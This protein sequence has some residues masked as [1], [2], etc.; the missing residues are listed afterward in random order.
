MDGHLDQIPTLDI[1][2]IKKYFVKVCARKESN[3]YSMFQGL[4]GHSFLVV[5]AYGI[6]V[7]HHQQAHIQEATELSKI[8]FAVHSKTHFL[9]VLL[10]S[11]A[12]WDVQT[13]RLCQIQLFVCLFVYLGQCCLP[14]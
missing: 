8:H 6:S 5:L 4:L 1:L 14:H 2:L 7:S 12:F 13:E 10:N 9:S 3:K 11:L